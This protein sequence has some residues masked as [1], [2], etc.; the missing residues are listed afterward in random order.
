[1]V[2][3]IELGIFLNFCRVCGKSD[4]GF[5]HLLVFYELIPA[6]SAPFIV[7]LV[8]LFAVCSIMGIHI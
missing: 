8:E 6:I 1:M 4:K 5:L 3:L 7:L 2:A